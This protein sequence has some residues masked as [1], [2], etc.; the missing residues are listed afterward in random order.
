MFDSPAPS[1]IHVPVLQLCGAFVKRGQ[2]LLRHEAA[3]TGQ[4]TR[5]VMG[6]P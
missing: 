1:R 2:P 3:C 5:R 6:H 4:G